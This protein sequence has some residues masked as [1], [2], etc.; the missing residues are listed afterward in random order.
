VVS[1]LYSLLRLWLDPLINPDAVYYLIAAEAWLDNGVDAALAIYWR[2]FY[3]IL[4]GG[5]ALISGLST[6]ASAHVVDALFAATLL[7]AVQLL[8]RELGGDVRTQAIGLVLFLLLPSLHEYRTMI[9]RDLGYW[10]AALSGLIVLIRYARSGHV[11][12]MG[13]FY[14]AVLIA[15]LFRPEAVVLVLLPVTLM[16][17]RGARDQVRAVIIAQVLLLLICLLLAMGALVSNG[18]NE[19]VASVLQESVRE[20]LR[21]L[22]TVPARFG[23]L[24]EAFGNGVLHAEFHDYAVI[25]LIAGIVAIVMSHFAAAIGWPVLLIAAI[26][27]RRELFKTLDPNALRLTVWTIALITTMLCVFLIIS[28]V[29]QTRFLMLPAFMVLVLAPFA[30]AYTRRSATQSG[31]QNWWRWVA[32]IAVAYLIFEA[33]CSMEHSKTYVLD[34]TEL[35]RQEAATDARVLSNDARIAYLSGHPFDFIDVLGARQLAEMSSQRRS[36]LEDDYDYWAIHLRA[37]SPYAAGLLDVLPAWREIG[38]TANRKGDQVI[39]LVSPRRDDGMPVTFTETP[40][41]SCWVCCWLGLSRHLC[42][43]DG[44][45]TSNGCATAAEPSS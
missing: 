18:I 28:P 45:A 9:G 42:S 35:I 21:L 10:T 13:V 32:G 34:A 7:V 41:G 6:L 3:S 25:G 37:R 20:P 44:A 17:R 22:A 1:L 19:F 11:L 14:G 5:F 12:L 43:N 26:G 4:I 39:V 23:E 24:R 40:P 27:F 29:M 38:R 30:V 31:R 33:W 8:I 16:F 15:M 36:S 2:P